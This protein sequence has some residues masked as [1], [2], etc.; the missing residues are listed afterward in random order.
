[1]RDMVSQSEDAWRIITMSFLSREWKIEEGTRNVSASMSFD[2]LFVCLYIY[3]GSWGKSIPAY[4]FFFP[5][6]TARHTVLIFFVLIKDTYQVPW[7]WVSH[8][9]LF[10][11]VEIV[12]EKEPK[13]KSLSSNP[14][15]IYMNG[16]W[17]HN[18]V[19]RVPIA[20]LPPTCSIFILFWFFWNLLQG[21]SSRWMLTFHLPWSWLWSS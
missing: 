2:T 6:K 8:I 10:W 17:V 15:N 11:N 18:R 16:P 14:S 13:V 7:R 5:I 9:L 20:M 12:R 19:C 4:N 1:M 3:Y 21:L